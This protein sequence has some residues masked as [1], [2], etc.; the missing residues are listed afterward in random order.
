MTLKQFIDKYNNKKIDFDGKFGSQCVDLIRKYIEEVL[1]INAYTAIPPI[2]GASDAW[3]KFNSEY[4]I[5]ENNTTEWIP[6]P[7]T[8]IIWNRHY[9]PYGHIAIVVSATKDKFTVFSQ[10]DPINSA[11]ILKEYTYKYVYGGLKPKN[12]PIETNELEEL[13]KYFNVKTSQELK[14]MVAKELGFLESARDRVKELESDLAG[15]KESVKSLRQ[16]LSDSEY[17]NEQLISKIAGKLSCE[18]TED[19]ILREL[20]KQANLSHQWD[21]KEREYIKKYN[22]LE[23]ERKAQIEALDTEIKQLKADNE[24]LQSRIE[25]LEKK[26]SDLNKP[27]ENKFLNW[28]KNFFTIKE[29]KL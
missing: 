22:E 15:E 5:K 3:T 4:F 13:L 14:D 24:Q 23:T 12:M 17:R 28:L 29:R 19:A 7:G 11:C 8:I 20:E 16:Q 1:N 10:N 27:S 26:I 2:E 25:N 18:Q 21:K 9:G 6:T